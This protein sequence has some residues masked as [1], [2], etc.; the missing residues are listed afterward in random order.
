MKAPGDRPALI[1]RAVRN[2]SEARAN[3]QVLRDVRA[4]GPVAFINDA[5]DDNDMFEPSRVKRGFGKGMDIN[6]DNNSAVH[7]YPPPNGWVH[8][9][10]FYKCQFGEKV[11]EY[12]LLNVD[13]KRNAILKEVDLAPLARR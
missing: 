8:P 10:V 12:A 4:N 1:L 9:F 7:K 5:N 6:W 2:N 3:G 11:Y 13:P